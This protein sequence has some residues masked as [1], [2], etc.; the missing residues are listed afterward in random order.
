[1]V[2]VIE[3]M[4]DFKTIGGKYIYTHTR[5]FVCVFVCVCTCVCIYVYI[6][7]FSGP[8]ARDLVVV[9]LTDTKRAEQ[10]ESPTVLR[11]IRALRWANRCP[12]LETD[13]NREPQLHCSRDLR[14]SQFQVGAG[15]AV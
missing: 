1:M 5:V 14:K 3:T 12:V 9:L 13:G 15:R 7:W 11:S 4:E 8:H 10:T 2:M 6:F